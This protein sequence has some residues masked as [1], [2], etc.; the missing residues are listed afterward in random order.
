MR[1]RRVIDWLTFRDYDLE[2][3]KADARIVSRQSRGSVAAQNGWYMSIN[4]LR[5]DSRKADAS[6][7]YLQKTIS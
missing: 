4:K 7:E 1:A 2:K 5:E 3:E 6:I